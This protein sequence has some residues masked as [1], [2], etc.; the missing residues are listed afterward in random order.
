MSDV[1]PLNSKVRFGAITTAAG[2]DAQYEQ[3]AREVIPILRR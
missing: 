1:L 2:R 3:F